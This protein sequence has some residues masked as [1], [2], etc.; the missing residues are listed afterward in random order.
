M[1]IYTIAHGWNIAYRVHTA[2][3]EIIEKL[4]NAGF[5]KSKAFGFYF[6]VVNDT[7]RKVI[8]SIRVKNES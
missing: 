6:C 3:A 2:N 7:S 1:R 5:V 8:K 4:L